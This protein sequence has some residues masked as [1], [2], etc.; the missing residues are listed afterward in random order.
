MFLSA[1]EDSNLC[2]WSE[3]GELLS[4]KNISAS[5][6]IWNLDY[7][8]KTGEIVSCGSLGKLNKFLLNEILY[9]NHQKLS[10]RNDEKIIPAKLKYLKNGTLVVVD[11]KMNIHLKLPTGNWMKVDKVTQHQNSVAIEVFEN[12]L[13]LA[14]K[15]FVDVFD[16]SEKLSM[17]ELTTEVLIKKILPETIFLSC[18]RAIHAIAYNEIVVS[19]AGGLCI[20]INVAAKSKILNIFQIPKSAEPWTTSVARIDDVW[21]VADRVGNLF[22]F[23]NDSGT[24]KVSIPVQKIWRLHGQLGVTT[25]QPQSDGFIKTTGNDGVVRTLFLNRKNFP[26]TIEVHRSEKTAVNWIGKVCSWNGKEYLLGFNDNYFAIYHHGQI[27]YEHRCGGRHRHWDVVLLDN[28][29]RVNFTYIQRKQLNVVEFILGDFDYDDNDVTWHTMD[30]NTM[31]ALDNGKLLIS[32]SEDTSIKLLVVETKEGEVVFR[33][34]ATVNSH[35]SNVKAFATVQDDNDFL[36]FSAGG[37]AQIVVTRLVER[38]FVKE[39]ISFKL[40]SQSENRNSSFSSNLDAETRFTSIFYEEKLRNLYVACS[41]GFL[42]ILRFTK[43]ENCSELRVIKEHFYGKC[44]LKVHVV[45]DI[46]LTMATDGFVCFWAHDKLSDDLRLIDRLKH[47]QSGINCF[48]VFKYADGSFLIGTSGD[49]NGIFITRFEI[50]G[51]KIKFHPTKSN[52]NAH[53]A[54]VTGLKFIAE[55]FL[56]T[57]SVDQTI[58]KLEVIDSV[59][60]VVDKKFTCISDVKGFVFLQ[61]E[62]IVV[63]GAGLEIVKITS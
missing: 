6:V 45:K 30:C 9:E 54:Q 3:K 4:K 63:F 23:Q 48:D 52:C 24:N 47:N 58:C 33:D 22:V 19:D 5:G 53:T 32:G 42:R 29:K 41:D 20:V 21:L 43:T 46:L 25:I 59:I 34:V 17:L 35:I 38:K 39:E 40:N 10:I 8:E 36:I 56:F 28:V 55:N 14:G 12:R 62:N 13:F 26:P 31:E 37:R 57:T 11:N 44:L 51:E 15:D 61:D 7:R 60:K 1:G 18:L 27:V 16:F 50:N 2:V 49:D